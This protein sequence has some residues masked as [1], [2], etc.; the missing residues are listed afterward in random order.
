MTAAETKQNT[1][2]L[3]DGAEAREVDGVSVQIAYAHENDARVGDDEVRAYI[4]RGNVQ[5]AS[6]VVT[7]LV[8][9]VDGEEVGIHYELAPV[10]FDRIRRI[11]GY[12]VGTMDRWN[13]AKTAEEADRVKH[14]ISRKDAIPTCTNGC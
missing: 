9:E 10:P 12:L 11:T 5:H 7:G 8:L 2:M 6:S 14:G 1:T 4:E 3:L 13:D